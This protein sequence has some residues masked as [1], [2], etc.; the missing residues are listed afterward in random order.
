MLDGYPDVLTV[1]QLAGIL[2][3]GLNS[4]YAL[5]KDGQISAVRVGKKYLIPKQLVLEFL[6][7]DESRNKNGNNRSAQFSSDVD[8]QWF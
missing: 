6:G 3:I 8:E 4:A 5:V 7:L 2:R 1:K